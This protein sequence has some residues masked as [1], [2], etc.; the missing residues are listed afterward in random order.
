M[1]VVA[2]A[3]TETV[4]GFA[5]G[6]VLSA[7]GG[8]AADRTSAG[9]GEA[10]GGVNFA[11]AVEPCAFVVVVPVSAEWPDPHLLG[12]EMGVP[13]AGWKGLG[14]PGDSVVPLETNQVEPPA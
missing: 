5:S 2:W 7:G 10:D 9:V 4:R 12:T 6:A 14:V 8:G 11:A 13:K 1:S 3:G